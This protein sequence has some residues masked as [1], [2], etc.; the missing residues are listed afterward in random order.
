M[1]ALS[2]R[3]RRKFGGLRAGLLRK[4]VISVQTATPLPDPL[5]PETPDSGLEKP[6]DDLSSTPPTV[7]S[8]SKSD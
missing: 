7:V 6:S 5:V 1:H 8:H 2:E 3:S 4:K